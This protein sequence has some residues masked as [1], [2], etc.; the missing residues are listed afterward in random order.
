MTEAIVFDLDEVDYHAHPALSST[1]ARQLLTAPALFAW[2]Q[3]H[4]T[5]HVKAFD[6]G[7]AVHARVLGTG[8][9]T[10]EIP[11]EV[12]SKSGTVGTD[13]ARAF[14]AE[15]RA[16][17]LIPLKAHELA[18]VNAIAESVLS[19]KT[20]RMLLEQEGHAE[21]SVFGTDPA[22]GVECRARFDKLP[23]GPGRRIAVDLKTKHG[24]AS[25]VKFA[26]TVADLGYHVQEAH[27]IDTLR[28]TGHHVDAFAFLVVEKEPPYLVATFV[29]NPD[30]QEIGAA[31]AARAR[32]LFARGTETGQWPGY[33]EEI[34]I[35][36]PPQWAVYD[37]IDAQEIER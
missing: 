21:A 6:A 28:F 19:H 18:E 9:Q 2:S 16:N 7:S 31:R 35:A 33:P 22:T 27:Y 10:V 4:P 1:G 34:Q 5:P 13:A 20:A 15:S 12:L 23:T 8:W 37:H 14:I 17:N 32:E 30:F 11:E 26:K 24:A 25:P 36:R 29:L 3:S